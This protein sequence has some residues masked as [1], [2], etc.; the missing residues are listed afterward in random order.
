MKLGHHKG[1]NAC[2]F[3]LEP[4]EGTKNLTNQNLE[5]PEPGKC[6][7]LLCKDKQIHLDFGK[8]RFLCDTCEGSTVHSESWEASLQYFELGMQ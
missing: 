4:H 2:V 5:L 6:I 1:T 3:G 7:L 8:G